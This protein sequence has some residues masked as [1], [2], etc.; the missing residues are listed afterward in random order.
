[1][2]PLTDV[3]PKPLLKAGAKRLIEYHLQGLASAG[4]KNVVINVSWLGQQ[5][6]DVLGDGSKYNLNIIYSDEGEQALETGG[7]IF[8]ALP[9]LGDAPFL[10][11]NGDV[12]T[13]YPYQTL[14]NFKLKHKA[15]LIL[16]ENPP[17][18]LQG[19]FSIN[20]GLLTENAKQKYTFSGIGI[21]SKDFFTAQ[22]SGKFPLAPMIRQCIAKG[23]IS[24][25]IYRGKWMDIGTVD[26][27]NEVAEYLNAE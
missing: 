7:G 18:N 10:V 4:F 2:R 15:H 5:I 13:D 1:M 20:N 24:G 3:T 11:I 14:Q 6:I 25:E 16:V 27:L 19:D 26:R 8:N 23:E 17:H 22:E 21:Y 12:W 9:L